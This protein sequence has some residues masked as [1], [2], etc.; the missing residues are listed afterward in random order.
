VTA[1]RAT[2]ERFWSEHDIKDDTL[3]VCERFRLVERY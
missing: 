1:W 3:V 2:H